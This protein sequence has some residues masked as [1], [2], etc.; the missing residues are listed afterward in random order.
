MNISEEQSKGDEAFG[1]V[2]AV[3]LYF[4]VIFLTFL[5]A[6]LL[7][8]HSHPLLWDTWTYVGLFWFYTTIIGLGISIYNSR[9]PL[10]GNPEPKDDYWKAVHRNL[11][12]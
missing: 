7:T 9:K 3:I 10:V 4:C 5:V 2:I 6:Y 1:I 8:S 11:R 12:T